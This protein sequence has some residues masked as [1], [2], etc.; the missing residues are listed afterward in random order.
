MFPFERFANT[1]YNW[2]SYI[3][4]F[5]DS[6]TDTMEESLYQV[7]ASDASLSMFR[8][9][10]GYENKQQNIFISES[11][12]VIFRSEYSDIVKLFNS[13]PVYGLGR[14]FILITKRALVDNCIK[15]VSLTFS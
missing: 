15:A 10:P 3:A 1:F 4:I 5:D 11:I 2:N 6:I 13:L 8:L 7:L 9:S 14:K 12:F